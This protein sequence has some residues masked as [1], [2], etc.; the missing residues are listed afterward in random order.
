MFIKCPQCMIGYNIPTEKLGDRPQKMRCTRCGT[1]FTVAR[2]SGSPPPGYEEF[3]GKHSTLPHEFA[4]LRQAPEK[5]SSEPPIII[6]SSI[7]PPPNK[8]N[9]LLG[10]YQPGVDSFRKSTPAPPR[11]PGPSTESQTTS[12][13]GVSK[14]SSVEDSTSAQQIT[15]TFVEE[16]IRQAK[17]KTAADREGA[18]PPVP[19]NSGSS[20]P[21]QTDVTIPVQGASVPDIYNNGASAW[22]TE[23]PLDLESFAIENTTPTSQRI[24]K[25]M[26]AFVVLVAA[27]LIFVA[28]RNGWS[29]S[30]DSFQNQVVSAFSGGDIENLPPEVDSLEVTLDEHRILLRKKK[31]PLLLATG[32]V[33]NNSRVML[34]HI[35][36][37]GR[38]FDAGGEIRSETRAPCNKFFKDS[39][40]K[41]M[42]K[43]EIRRFY[44]KKGKLFNCSI[45]GETSTIY[46]L[47]F[48]NLPADY[49]ET[50]RLEVMPVS[51]SFQKR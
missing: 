6:E 43:G 35:V 18:P 46:Q 33:F 10:I 5:R 32:K 11:E 2:R 9:T 28:Y 19:P 4:F 3:T 41:R 34:T 47:V 39:R 50:F 8:E 20:V 21:I 29:L 40:L 13:K 14:A 12:E 26:T 24:G 1:V 45:R 17:E 15:D 25:V 49:D 22:E 44:R 42:G 36:L 27:F 51:A 7:P 48:E 31:A 23:A 30:F 37:R 38:L 16:A